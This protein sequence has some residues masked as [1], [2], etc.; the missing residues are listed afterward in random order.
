MSTVHIAGIGDR[1]ATAYESGLSNKTFEFRDEPRRVLII[2]EDGRAYIQRMMSQTLQGQGFDVISM[3]E[4]GYLTNS[5]S[6]YICAAEHEGYEAASARERAAWNEA[7]DQRKAERADRRR[8][9]AELAAFA[10]VQLG[11]AWTGGEP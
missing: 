4:V 1:C 8:D 3:D 9:R 11:E 6:T 10:N 7:V 2:N 5:A